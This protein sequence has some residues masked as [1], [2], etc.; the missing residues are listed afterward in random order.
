MNKWAAE[1]GQA[2]WGGGA[3]SPTRS[4]GEEKTKGDGRKHPAAS[5]PH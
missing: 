2:G 3:T 4:Q 5:R 1:Y